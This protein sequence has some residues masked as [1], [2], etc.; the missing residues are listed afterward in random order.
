MS[1][2]VSPKV[3]H[4]SLDEFQKQKAKPEIEAI[5]GHLNGGTFMECHCLV[6][7]TLGIWVP[8]LVPVFQKLDAALATRP[9]PA[10]I[11]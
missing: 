5:L 9:L 10:N 3:R 6:A 8:E 11:G 1:E 4:I 2:H 7:E